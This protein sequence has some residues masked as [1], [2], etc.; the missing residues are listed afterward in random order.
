MEFAPVESTN[1]RSGFS[2]ATGGIMRILKEALIIISR[3]VKLFSAISLLV[4]IP[5]SL[6]FLVTQLAMKPQ[7][8]IAN[9]DFDS[10]NSRLLQHLKRGIIMLC[11]ALMLLALSWILSV[12]S[13]VSTT[14]ASAITYSDQK[15]LSLRELL[16]SITR[17]CKRAAVTWVYITLFNMGLV[18]VVVLVVMLN[19]YLGLTV[20]GPSLAILASV[21][22]VFLTPVWM[23]GV[24]VSVLEEGWYGMRALKKAWD[25]ITGRKFQGVC[26]SALVALAMLPVSAIDRWKVENG[27]ESMLVPLIWG[28]LSVA[29]SVLLQLFAHAAYTVFY[30]ECK[31]SCGEKVDL[32][33]KGRYN[34]IPMSPSR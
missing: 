13:M 27:G 5:S 14:Y 18:M 25:L 26:L 21:L 19:I 32:E 12:F 10:D 31:G 24:A 34:L 6:L 1:K 3:N 16:A 28:V 22:N 29:I 4:F 30:Y 8:M 17:P 33:E 23:L 9:F 15:D 11:E 2:I 20:L 7:I